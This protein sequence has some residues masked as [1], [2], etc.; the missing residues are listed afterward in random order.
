MN[1]VSK[2]YH[3]TYCPHIATS[4]SPNFL[5]VT[6]CRNGHYKPSHR[7]FKDLTISWGVSRYPVSSPQGAGSGRRWR[8]CFASRGGTGALP[9]ARQA[10]GRG[11]GGGVTILSGPGGFSESGATINV[12]GGAG[13][14]SLFIITPNGSPGGAGVVTISTIPE[15][16]SLTL[17]GIG[18]LGVLGCARYAGCRAAA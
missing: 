13:G 17:L 10:E 11:G 3:T 7:D 15:P 16:A 8:P 18:L 9:G 5:T 4:I 2:D 12:A 1:N 6:D 14:R